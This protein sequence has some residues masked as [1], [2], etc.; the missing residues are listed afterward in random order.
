MASTLKEAKKQAEISKDFHIIVNH[1]VDGSNLQM[2]VEAFGLDEPSF[3]KA[4]VYI[5]KMSD[6]KNA[7]NWFQISNM[8]HFKFEVGSRGSIIQLMVSSLDSDLVKEIRNAYV[9]FEVTQLLNTMLSHNFNL[10]QGQG[11]SLNKKFADKRVPAE[12]FTIIN[13]IQKIHESGNAGIS[14]YRSVLL[15]AAEILRNK[16]NPQGL[17]GGWFQGTLNPSSKALY[18]KLIYAINVLETLF[19]KLPTLSSEK[20]QVSKFGPE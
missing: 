9:K 14:D 11:R 15:E 7:K 3:E 4:R 17:F 2:A 12:I 6:E 10:A 18:E 16:L 20:A 5:S 1:T 13:N 19:S 8:G